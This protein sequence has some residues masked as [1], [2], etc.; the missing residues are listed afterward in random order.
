MKLSSPR[1]GA[2]CDQLT[3]EGSGNHD[4]RVKIM[5]LVWYMQLIG[6][7]HIIIENK[8]IQPEPKFL[9][10]LGFRTQKRKN[11]FGTFGKFQLQITVK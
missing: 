6:Y 5:K 7:V 4:M 2:Q 10:G 1:G 3:F 8:N 11:N 9:W